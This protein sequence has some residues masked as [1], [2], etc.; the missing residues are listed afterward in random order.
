MIYQN[1][2]VS[3]WLG[4]AHGDDGLQ[5]D[6]LP[7]LVCSTCCF[8]PI[9]SSTQP[10]TILA[11][12]IP[13]HHH[14][15]QYS[16]S[17]IILTSHQVDLPINVNKRSNAKTADPWSH[18]GSWRRFLPQDLIII[19]L[20]LTE[21]VKEYFC[22]KIFDIILNKELLRDFEKAQVQTARGEEVASRNL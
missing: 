11:V 21:V 9:H 5:S 17:R 10:I 15:S 18:R 12:N 4:G 20:H 6:P 7:S 8:H 13:D 14:L 19:I 16:K 2:N 22:L 3:E 1:Q